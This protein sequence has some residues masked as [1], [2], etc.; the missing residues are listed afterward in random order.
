MEASRLD[1]CT[2]VYWRTHIHISPHREH[3]ESSRSLFVGEQVSEWVYWL[4]SS[5]GLARPF[6][7]PLSALL[8]TLLSSPCTLSLYSHLYLS[9]FAALNPSL[10]FPLFFS[11]VPL[12]L[13]RVRLL[14][15][16]YFLGHLRIL[17]TS[18]L[19]Q[20]L[21]LLRLATLV[22]AWWIHTRTH[23]FM[24]DVQE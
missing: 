23:T 18:R 12:A 14:P 7:R 8:T 22:A 9:L 5:P 13:P 1:V 2:Y 17:R 21:Y 6:A 24:L 11:P 3:R 20:V 16:D 15:F 19:P 10:S 4:A